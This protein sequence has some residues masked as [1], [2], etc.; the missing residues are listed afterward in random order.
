MHLISFIWSKFINTNLLLKR[1]EKLK[2]IQIYY[3]LK[4]SFNAT[5]GFVN[6]QPINYN[7]CF[8]FLDNDL[9]DSRWLVINI[10]VSNSSYCN[11]AFFLFFY[12]LSPLAHRCSVRNQSL[13]SRKIL[14]I[15]VDTRW[16]K[17]FYKLWHGLLS[18]LHHSASLK[19]AR[20]PNGR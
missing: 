16:S 6:L 15:N 1:I 18:P 12:F 5:F 10:W 7:L 13:W 14:F 2:L 17:L 3:L 20:Y 19:D 8:W 9:N 4:E 11:V